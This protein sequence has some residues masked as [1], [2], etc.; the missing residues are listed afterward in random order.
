MKEKFTILE[1]ARLLGIQ[2]GSVKVAI[3]NQRL[4]AKKNGRYWVVL[5]SDLEEYKNTRWQR[6]FPPPKGEITVIDAERKYNISLQ[7][8]Y[9]LMRSNQLSFIKRGTNPISFRES[10]LIEIMAQINS[11][12]EARIRA[13]KV[14][15]QEQYD[16]AFQRRRIIA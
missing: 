16:R 6:I 14:K 4:K 2:E 3:Y 7:S 12:K 8:I 10:D 15:K 9:H 11:V 5:L 1:A 13:R